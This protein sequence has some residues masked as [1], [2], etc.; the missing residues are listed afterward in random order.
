VI[1]V[2]GRLFDGKTSRGTE[3]LVTTVD[4]GLRIEADGIPAFWAWSD[5]PRSCLTVTGATTL[6]VRGT[7]TLEVAGTAFR[8][9]LKKAYP[10]AHLFRSPFETWT[11]TPGRIVLTLAAATAALTLAFVV[12]VPWAGDVL[13][14]SLPA[15]AEIAAGKSLQA[16]MTAGLK[17]FPDTSTALQEFYDGLHLPTT[18]ST[19]VTVVD[20]GKTV[21]AFALMGGQVIVY[22][23]L[24]DECRTPDELAGVLAHETAHGELHHSARLIGRSLAGAFLMSYLLADPTG[25]T[26]AVLGNVDSLRSLQFS[27]EMEAQAD[28]WAA[29]HLAGKTDPRALGDLLDRIDPLNLPGWAN[30]LSNHPATADRVK[31]L[32]AAPPVK[33]ASELQDLFEEVQATLEE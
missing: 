14:S 33:P 5:L 18:L 17:T 27:R 26:G 24:I 32:K 11:S 4:G 30:F 31:A 6:V 9:A 16:Q 21:N 3:V 19:H 10:R 15:E 22:R 25:I 8:Q 29:E 20:D 7:Q 23:K 28:N 13:A 1:T 12:L 2:P